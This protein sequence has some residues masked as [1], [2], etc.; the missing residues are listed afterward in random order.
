[1]SQSE[2]DF[3]NL[4]P[5]IH[6]EEGEGEEG[7]LTSYAD[8]ITLLLAVFVMLFSMSTLDESKMK[9]LSNAMSNYIAKKEVSSAAKE[10]VTALER[11][12][13]GMRLLSIMLDLG[14]TDDVLGRILKIQG[15]AAEQRRLK[16]LSQ[17]LGIAGNG[18]F[19]TLKPQFDFVFSDELLFAKNSA[20]LLPTAQTRLRKLAPRL[21][22]VVKKEMTVLEISGHSDSSTSQGISN[23]ELSSKRAM[24]VFKFL[25]EEGE[26]PESKMRVVGKGSTD[27]IYPAV[28]GVSSSKN[29]RVVISVTNLR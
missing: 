15:N 4:R 24:S 22:E 16:E 6:D 27:P 8:L 19:A 2:P 28:Q 13:E 26:V 29:R 5:V 25:R 11:Q 23:L 3:K 1:M 10:D 18:N 9:E 14:N 21:R 17:K 12:A 7:W 20:D